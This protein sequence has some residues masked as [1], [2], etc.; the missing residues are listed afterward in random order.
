VL[1]GVLAQAVLATLVY[2]APMLRGRTTGARELM[3]ARLETGARTRA[4]VFGA[5]VVACT[6]GASPLLS[7]VPLVAL[8]WT[9]LGG[10][11][12]T[13]LGTAL[14]PLPRA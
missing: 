11:L 2:L 8:G 9:L 12:V 4:A 5:G 13:T 7:G 14:R 10:V 3:I 1:T 6:L